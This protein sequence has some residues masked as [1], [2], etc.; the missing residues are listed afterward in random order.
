[1]ID[2]SYLYQALENLLFISLQN[3]TAR[4]YKRI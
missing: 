3:K 1:M 2:G 4:Q